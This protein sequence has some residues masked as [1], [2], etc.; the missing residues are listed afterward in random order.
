MTFCN[1]V[2]RQGTRTPGHCLGDTK[3]FCWIILSSRKL[4]FAVPP[5]NSPVIKRRHEALCSCSEMLVPVCITQ[6]KQLCKYAPGYPAEWPE[7]Q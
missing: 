7:C 3:G 2:V 6:P 4:L 5:V 1:P